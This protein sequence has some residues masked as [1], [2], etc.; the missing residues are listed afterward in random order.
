MVTTP[1][2]NA[3]CP[4]GS[5]KKYKHCCLRGPPSEGKIATPPFGKVPLE[6]AQAFSL[7]IGKSELFRRYYADVRPH[8]GG[9]SV[10]LDLHLPQGVRASITR[11]GGT[12][13]LRLRTAVCPVEH[14]RLVAHELGHLLQD[15]QG[16]PSVAS[17]N[18]HPAAAALNSA[19]R[20]PLTDAMLAG[21]GFDGD[22]DRA[23]EL[24]EH[25]HQLRSTAQPPADAAGRAHWIANCLGHLLDQ[26]VL[27]ETPEGT[28][29]FDWFSRRYPQIAAD[30][31]RIAREVVLI[32]FDTPGKMFTAMHKAHSM[33]AAGGAIIPPAAPG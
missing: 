10:V 1:D 2:R 6:E 17:P 7:L 14:A 13:Y 29:F 16:F 18:D 23:A 21:Y 32:G 5:G 26:H 30:A 8:L 15:Q 22:P 9:F 20:D 24:E 4:C 31:E 12:S 3:P 25:Y 11:W 33:L 19:L 27:G 28:Q